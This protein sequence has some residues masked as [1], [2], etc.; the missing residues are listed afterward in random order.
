MR[1]T[2]KKILALAYRPAVDKL[3]VT[4]KVLA[5]CNTEPRSRYIIKSA[6][7]DFEI[8]LSKLTICNFIVQE[9][10]NGDR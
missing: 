8:T 6:P 5:G 9:I 1:K 7:G 4:S 10:T 2:A 3:N